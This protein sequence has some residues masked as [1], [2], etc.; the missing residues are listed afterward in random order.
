ML[1][2][3]TL[4]AAVALSFLGCASAQAQVADPAKFFSK[5]PDYS[6]PTMSPTGDY[7]AVD[8]PDGQNRALAL[9]R[10]HRQ[11]K[12]KPVPLLRRHRP[13]GCAP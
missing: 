1:R 12:R 8:T 5:E 4:W 2:K 13:L 3:T 10:I 6:D 7:I 9:I 11:A